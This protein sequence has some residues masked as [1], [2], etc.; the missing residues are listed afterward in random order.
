MV[1]MGMS[2]VTFLVIIVVRLLNDMAVID[3]IF[4]VATYTYGP[5]L[6]AFAFGLF[7]PLEVRDRLVPLVGLAAPMI[8]FLINSSTGNWLGFATLPV[9]GAIMFIG[10]LAISKGRNR[11]S[12]EN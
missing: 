2:V 7:T 3:A 5:L 6:G 11:A 4:Q 12:Q 10:M 1:H 9:N 8:C